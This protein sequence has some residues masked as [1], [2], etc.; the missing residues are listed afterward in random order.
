MIDI[1]VRFHELDPYG[2]VNHAAYLHYLEA[3]RIA[4]LAEVGVDLQA[5]DQ[6]HGIQL[7]VTDLQ[8]TYLGA[9]GT[10]DQ[11]TVSCEVAELR[12]VRAVFGQEV[13]RGGD[14]LVR[15]TVRTAVVGR[16]GRPKP[17][18]QLLQRALLGAST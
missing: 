11:L 2:H 13:R 18:P 15:A 14:T 16:D 5:L 8:I 6:Q 3:A 10:G 7:V 4:A 12:R 1:Q 17:L 9:A